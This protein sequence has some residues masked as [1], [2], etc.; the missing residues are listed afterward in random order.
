[1]QGRLILITI[2]S[3]EASEAGGGLEPVQS[4]LRYTACKAFL[5]TL[6]EMNDYA[7][8]HE[9]ISENMT[10]QIT[11]D[12]MR[13]VQ[14]LKQERKSGMNIG[15]SSSNEKDVL[16][17]RHKDW[18]VVAHTRAPSTGGVGRRQGEKFSANSMTTCDTQ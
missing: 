3:S 8:Q 13:Y 16:P 2:S 4:V 6:N 5:S 7:G 9:V 1:M 12:L 14:E 15:V 10:S 11:V 17:E 18:G